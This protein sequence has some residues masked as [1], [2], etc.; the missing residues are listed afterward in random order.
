MYLTRYNNSNQI[1]PFPIEDLSN[2]VFS[3]YFE[4]MNNIPNSYSKV[5]ISTETFKPISL[6][7]NKINTNLGFSEIHIV[8]SKSKKIEK[9]TLG[10]SACL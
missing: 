8:K 1:L 4:G 6:E 2:V 9:F 5:K 3:K 7:N 10:N